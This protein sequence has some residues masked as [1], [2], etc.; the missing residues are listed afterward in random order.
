MAQIITTSIEYQYPVTLSFLCNLISVIMI[1]FENLASI[2]FWYCWWFIK[3]GRIAWSV[4][5]ALIKDN[6]WMNM[7]TGPVDCFQSSWA[8]FTAN[9]WFL[10]GKFLTHYLIFTHKW[11][12]EGGINLN[13]VFS[14][15]I[16]GKPFLLL[17]LVTDFSIRLTNNQKISF[18]T[19][20]TS[21]KST[22][23]PVNQL[24]Y[25]FRIKYQIS[26]SKENVNGTKNLRNSCCEV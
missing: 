13:V 17:P 23:N 14:C 25:Q 7:K 1:H 9:R 19:N 16:T 4:I 12:P 5:S 10:Y 20:Q 15:D 24:W 18:D 6:Y 3:Y 2:K 26:L 21:S 22:N 8:L 11:Q